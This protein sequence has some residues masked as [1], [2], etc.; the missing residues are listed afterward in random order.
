MSRIEDAVVILYHFILYHPFVD[1]FFLFQLRS[2]L[3]FRGFPFIA[4]ALF[5]RFL[6]VSLTFD[7]DFPSGLF[8]II[9]IPSLLILV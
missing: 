8:Y 2:M 3:V 5:V 7:F 1:V 4:R 9:S 6:L